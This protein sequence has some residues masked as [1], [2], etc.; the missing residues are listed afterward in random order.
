MFAKKGVP[1]VLSI[2]LRFH[3]FLYKYNASTAE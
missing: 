2:D 1:L 3:A